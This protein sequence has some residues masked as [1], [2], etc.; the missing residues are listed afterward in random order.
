MSVTGCSVLPVLLAYIDETGDTGDPAKKGSSSCY[1]LG[2]VLVDDRKWSPAFEGLLNLRGGIRKSFGIPMRA[3]LKAN[4]LIRG[5]GPLARLP[6]LAPS[7][8]QWIYRAHLR[9]L[10]PL[11]VR[12]FAIVVDKERT[13]VTGNDCLHL[14]WETLLQ[15]LRRTSQVEDQTLMIFHDNGENDAIR[16]EVRKARR[17]LTSGSAWGTGTLTFALPHLLDDPVPRDSQQSYFTQVADMVAYAG[18]RSYMAPSP[19]VARIVP[20]DT[21]LQLG[22]ATHTAVS[23]LRPRGLP[24]VVI[25]M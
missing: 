22:P 12:A 8:R 10:A 3:E 15:R 21:W 19:G 20:Q 17:Y 2:V 11:D 5:N 13:R 7:Q 16:K 14:A 24:G 23:G 18:W 1:A 6:P 9:A 25:R 4:Y